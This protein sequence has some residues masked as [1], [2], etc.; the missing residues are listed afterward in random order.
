[1]EVR[2]T[3]SRSHGE[4]RMTRAANSP[5]SGDRSEAARALDD[6]VRAVQLMVTEATGISGRADGSAAASNR[7]TWSSV[8]SE[9]G[10][11][12]LARSP[13]ARPHGSHYG[14]GAGGKYDGVISDMS[15]PHDDAAAARGW[16]GSMRGRREQKGQLDQG[17]MT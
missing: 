15:V 14:E 4:D 8:P 7:A 9:E 11:T 13:R 5:P 6:S 3:G 10:G 16:A 17:E 2:A 1:M 12:V